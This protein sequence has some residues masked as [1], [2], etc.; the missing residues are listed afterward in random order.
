MEFVTFWAQYPRKVGKIAAK[1]ALDK[2]LKLTT[3][4]QILQGIEV[5]KREK[6]GKEPSWIPHPATWLNE[7]R[8]DDE[9][10]TTSKPAA[11]SPWN[12]DF[13]K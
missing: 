13:Y 7:G 10:S 8:W 5:L 4:E 9:P 6:E 3:L 1:T 11:S 12:K 2:A